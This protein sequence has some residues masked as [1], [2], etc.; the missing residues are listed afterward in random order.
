MKS[1]EESLLKFFLGS[2]KCDS[3]RDTPKQNHDFFVSVSNV[4]FLKAHI[5]ISYLSNSEKIWFSLIGRGEKKGCNTHLGTFFNL[6]IFTNQY[7]SLR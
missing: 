6:D 7:I 1:Q 4:D 5:K 2:F 3:M